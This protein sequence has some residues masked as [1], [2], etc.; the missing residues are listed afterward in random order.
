MSKSNEHLAI[1]IENDPIIQ[2][3]I[4]LQITPNQ[5]SYLALAYPEQ[6]MDAELEANLPDHFFEL[7]KTEKEA[8]SRQSDSKNEGY[9]LQ[10]PPPGCIKVD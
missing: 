1:E 10:D 8:R 9:L 5:E 3:L 2:R 7:P 4:K 6:K